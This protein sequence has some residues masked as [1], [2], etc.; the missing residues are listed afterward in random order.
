M[1]NK[2]SI[3]VILTR[4]MIAVFTAWTGLSLATPTIVEQILGDNGDIPLSGKIGGA[5]VATD[6]EWAFVGS[7]PGPGITVG[8][9]HCEVYVY[10]YDYLLNL[11]GDGSTANTPYL[12]LRD[13]FGGSLL[14]CA[15]PNYAQ[16]GSSIST[17]NGLLLVGASLA[18]QGGANPPEYGRAFLYRYDP[19]NVVTNGSWSEI[20]GI[21]FAPNNDEQN[22]AEFGAAVAIYKPESWP[23]LIVVGAPGYDGNNG[24]DVD[25]GKAYFYSYD[26]GATVTYINAVEGKFA[27][28]R[29]GT[30]VSTN[31][32]DFLVGAPGYDSTPNAGAGFLY[33][34]SGNTLTEKQ[35][36]APAVSANNASGTS[37]SLSPGADPATPANLDG[38]L[39][40]L[41][42]ANP[43]A[44]SAEIIAYWYNRF[45]PGYEVVNRLSD[46]L[47]GGDVD[48][49]G[50]IA[51][52]GFA[53]TSTRQYY[54]N[55]SNPAIQANHWRVDVPETDFGRD[56]D[57]N[58]NDRILVNGNANDRA[59][60]YYTPCGKGGDLVGY[61]WAM[62]GTACDPGAATINAIFADDLGVYN[63]NW[64]IY[65]QVKDFSGLQSAY[66]KLTASET[67][68][69]TMIPGQGYWIVADTSS[70]WQLDS[71]LGVQTAVEVDPV[72]SADRLN[73]EEVAAVYRYDLFNT[74]GGKTAPASG[75][76]DV[77]LMLSNPFPTPIFWGDV[78]L[79]VTDPGNTAYYPVTS[80]STGSNFFEQTSPNSGVYDTN[81]Y[82][83]SADANGG[84]G[85]YISISPTTPGFIQP[86]EP[87]EG[88]YIRLSDV[89]YNKLTGSNGLTTTASSLLYAERK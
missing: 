25:S 66:V 39:I 9:R 18:D 21:A 40:L 57:L 38:S 89:G 33:S 80:S 4:G 81:A 16:Y 32:V 8:N 24:A 70:R 56:I 23:A 30:S 12:K 37:V 41:G 55:P 46:T 2:Q 75:V 51:A 48:L 65:K 35:I 27:G 20:S 42:D 79:A 19:Q 85:G 60:A 7:P 71:P 88:F 11:W 13:T 82:V 15:S 72:P 43:V 68:T 5:T 47:A 1:M 53:G 76:G 83:Y 45:G 50:G 64:V 28:D 61:Q 34:F 17:S 31:G 78:S 52:L 86:I 69:D 87:N 14:N 10:K 62:I 26:G 29:F 36:L 49:D 44:T 59:Y 73:P 67:T 74:L 77:K 54:I 58:G 63:S 3:K 6:G 22:G 84:N